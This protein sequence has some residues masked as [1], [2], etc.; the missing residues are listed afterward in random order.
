M[1]LNRLAPMEILPSWI[2]RAGI[3][4]VSRAERAL[5]LTNYLIRLI[6]MLMCPH[7]GVVLL[8]LMLMLIQI[9]Q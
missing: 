3:P 6:E 4:K 8:K 5:V 7:G 1:A 9:L 2:M